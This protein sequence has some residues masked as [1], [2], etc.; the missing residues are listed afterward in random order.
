MNSA[1]DRSAS[2]RAR[3]CELSALA[4]ELQV[5]HAGD[6]DRILEAEEQARRG[7]LVR[8]HREQ[9]AAVERHATPSA[10]LIAR[11]PAEHVG[12][13][14]LARPVRPH[15]R[16]HLAG[17]DGRQRHPVQDRLVGD[18][19]VEVFDMQHQPTL[20]SKL[21]PSSFCASTAN[22]IGSC[23]STSRAKPLTISAT[24]ASCVEP[25]AIA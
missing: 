24:A 21:I 8:L 14:R 10:H 6:L 15:D 25:A 16:M 7:A 17:R 12:E 3:R 9:V 1:P 20:P 4:Q 13:R 5:G 23:F 11:P 19:R 22:S 18:G 2:P